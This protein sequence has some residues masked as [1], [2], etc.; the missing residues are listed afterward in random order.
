MMF[1][2]SVLGL[3]LVF[4]A[5]TIWAAFGTQT[6]GV[7]QA[8]VRFLICLPIAGVLL[9]LVRAAMKHERSRR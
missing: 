5:P 3:A 7:D 6:I 1:R 4:S 8:L 9:G 2:W